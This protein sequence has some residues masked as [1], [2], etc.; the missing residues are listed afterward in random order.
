MHLCVVRC[1]SLCAMFLYFYIGQWSMKTCVGRFEPI[2]EKVTMCACICVLIFTVCH[3]VYSVFWPGTL[4]QFMQHLDITFRR[5]PTNFRPRINKLESTK[6]REQKS[7]GSYYYLDDWP[8]FWQVWF[9]CSYS[10]HLCCILLAPRQLSWPFF[11]LLCCSCWI[12]K[13][14]KA[15]LSDIRAWVNHFDGLTNGE[16]P[17]AFGEV[18]FSG[19]LNE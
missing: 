12:C 9:I 3:Y 13:L 17:F 1:A 4:L 5:D 18:L 15:S 10:T 8:D 6:D 14:W 7:A 19:W 11:C 16:W 2:Q